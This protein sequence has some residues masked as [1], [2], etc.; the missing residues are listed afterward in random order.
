M[1]LKIF[2]W[3]TVVTLALA[4]PLQGF[5]ASAGGVCMALGHHGMEHAGH[6]HHQQADT[7]AHAE[8]SAAGHRHSHDKKPSG[9]AHC[10]PCAACCATAAIAFFIPA[11]A[12]E[13]RAQSAVAAPAASFSGVAP[14]R[15]DRPPRFFLA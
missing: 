7:H 3:L 14:E 12:I 2:R 10:P 11:L 6:Q 8:E 9:P 1:L 15:L 13:Q 4:I 5:A